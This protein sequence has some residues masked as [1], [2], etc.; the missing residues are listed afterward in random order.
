MTLG[1]RQFVGLVVGAVALASCKHEER[2]AHCGMKID[3]KSPFLAHIEE[4][5][6]KTLTFDTPRCALSK[7]LEDGKK[8][9]VKVQ[10][11]YD[12]SWR[13][14]KG[15]RFVTGSDVIGPMGPAL[16]PVDAARAQKFMKDHAGKKNIGLDD[17][18]TEVLSG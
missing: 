17:V 2:C 7:W 16:V 13:D 5:G 1:R 9:T 8:G 6:G 10:D 18:T 11:F 3:P 4:P 15:M 14:A 12:R